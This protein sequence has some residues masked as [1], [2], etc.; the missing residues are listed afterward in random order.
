MPYRFIPGDPEEREYSRGTTV[1]KVDGEIQME[2]ARWSNSYTSPITG[3]YSD[4]I[5]D[6]LNFVF[7][8]EDEIAHM[9]WFRP[10][11][12]LIAGE[13]KPN[14]PTRWLK[15]VAAAKYGETP[16]EEQSSLLVKSLKSGIPN[17]YKEKLEYSRKVRTEAFLWEDGLW[18][19]ELAEALIK[20]AEEV[21][22]WRFQTLIFL[23]EL[24]VKMINDFVDLPE[25]LHE[26][27]YDRLAHIRDGITKLAVFRLDY[28]KPRRDLLRALERTPRGCRRILSHMENF[29]EEIRI[30]AAA[31]G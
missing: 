7:D 4:L 20:P 3:T 15:S 1:H 9:N 18:Y 26:G 19:E 8:T 17:D 29:I 13:R 24:L 6:R 23:R 25:Y 30:Q 10:Y 16:K 2:P 12:A 22:V 21:A 11:T 27:L 31:A 28:D 14:A 5:Y